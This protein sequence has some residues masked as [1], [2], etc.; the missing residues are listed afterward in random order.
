LSVRSCVV[1]STVLLSRIPVT[2]QQQKQDQA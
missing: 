2:P 1:P